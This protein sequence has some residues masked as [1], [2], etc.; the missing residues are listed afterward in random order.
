MLAHGERLVAPGGPR[1]RAQRPRE[2]PMNY[3]H[4]FH[5]GNPGDVLK[6]LVLILLLDHLR[7]KTTPFAYVETHAGRGLYDLAAS[8][9][10]RTAEYEAGIGRLWGREPDSPSLARYLEIVARFNQRTEARTNTWEGELRHYPGS[11][12]IA[13]ALLR[14]DDRMILCELHPEEHQALRRQLADD[15]RAAI[16]RVDGYQGLKAFLPPPRGRGLVL[17]DPSFERAD[18][19]QALVKGLILAH[20]RF[21][22]GT[23]AAWLPVKQSAPLHA[24]EASLLAADLP[25]I[26]RVELSTATDSNTDRMVGSRM[27]IVNPPWR[28]DDT[29]RRTLPE[30]T[31]KLAIDAHGGSWR[32]DWLAR[33]RPSKRT[34]KRENRP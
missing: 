31:Q 2:P 8:S 13:Q 29:L 33:E 7:K 9:A 19:H 11:P 34:S 14:D 23:L 30:L 20:R 18:E 1:Y 26:L 10:S 25:E 12:A 15:R 5:A 22:A 24:F 32:V 17:M 3:R 28:L 27:L 4:A 6:H 21:P 16:H